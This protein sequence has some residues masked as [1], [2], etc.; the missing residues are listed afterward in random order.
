MLEIITKTFRSYGFDSMETPIVEF[1][2]VL[3]GEKGDTGK[4]TFSIFSEN[5]KK[6][7]LGLR[8]DHTVPFARI[9]AGNPYNPKNKTG[10]QLP[11]KRMV[12]GPAFRGERPQEG[13]YRQFYQFDIDKNT[14]FPSNLILTLY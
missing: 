11:F 1:N 13:R 12:V 2:S 4:Q 14:R 7:S 6:E 10:I 9:L 3:G 8:F 5:T